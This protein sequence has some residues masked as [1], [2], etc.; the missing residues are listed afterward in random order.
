M[1]AHPSASIT[2]EQSE[3]QILDTAAI[4]DVSSMQGEFSLFVKQEH[5]EK[6]AVC[7]S[8]TMHAYNYPLRI[9][10]NKRMLGTP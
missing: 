7:S 5:R 6:C 3:C 9:V 4:R 10:P 8:G 1:V 2:E